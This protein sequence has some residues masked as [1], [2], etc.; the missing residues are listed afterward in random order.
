MSDDSSTT[1]LANQK[2]TE[3]IRSDLWSD[4]WLS[5]WQLGMKEMQRT[6]WVWAKSEWDAKTYARMQISLDEEQYEKILWE[7]RK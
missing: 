4:L 3:D 2:I 6:L 1:A 7:Q 5:F